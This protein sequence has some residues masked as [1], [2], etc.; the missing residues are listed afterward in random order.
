MPEQAAHSMY[1][2]Y[3]EESPDSQLTPN[4]LC[5]DRRPTQHANAVRSGFSDYEEEH[6]SHR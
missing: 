5:I 1:A 2:F 4:T 3:R 6:K